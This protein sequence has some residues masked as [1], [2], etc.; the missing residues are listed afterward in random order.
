MKRGGQKLYQ[1]LDK[2]VAFL[3]ANNIP[4]KWEK[5][6]QINFKTILWIAISSFSSISSSSS[7]TCPLLLVESEKLKL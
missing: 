7:M 2:S 5:E 4:K 3:N 1:N 6:K